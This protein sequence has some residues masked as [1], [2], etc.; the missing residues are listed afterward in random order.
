M[1]LELVSITAKDGY[2]ISKKNSDKWYDAL[3]C[4]SYFQF[5]G[6]PPQKTN[7][8]S[9]VKFDSKF[10]TITQKK[11]GKEI[12]HSY[13]LKNPELFPNLELFYLKEEVVASED[14]Y[15]NPIYE[16][17]FEDI[18]S[19]YVYTVDKLPDTFEEVE[20]TIEDLGETVF[21]L[22]KNPKFISPHYS[23]FTEITQPE[24]LRKTSPCFLTSQESYNVVRD[25]I[26]RNIDVKHA[27]ITS[28]YNFCF[29]VEKLIELDKPI[30]YQ[31]DINSVSFRKKKSK[32]ETKY[33]TARSVKV[34]EMTYSPENYQG[35]TPIQQFQGEN[36]EDLENKIQIFLDDLMKK[37]NEPLKDCEHCNGMGVILPDDLK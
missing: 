10:T 35:Y 4:L 27:R 26:K 29:S 22:E 11:S 12:N 24:I 9:W 31:V 6:K 2:F 17:F 34:F 14:S 25:Y 37:I 1:V 5:D 8:Q 32:Y 30:P 15:R 36:L 23:L 20:Y 3:Q 19:L 7:H 13:V 28:D 16:P 33:R 18:S 21:Q